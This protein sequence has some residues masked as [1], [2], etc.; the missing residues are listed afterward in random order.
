MERR[1]AQH[2]VDLSSL[3]AILVTHEHSDHC[4]GVAA[5]AKHFNLPVYLSHGTYASDRLGELPQVQL[6]DA[7]SSFAIGDIDVDAVAVPHDAR[8]PVQYRF[9]HDRHTVGVLT[10]L[11]FV[12]PHVL[13]HYSACDVLV[14]EFNHDPRMLAHGP[15]P[16]HLKRRVGG[17]W[18]HLSND[19]AVSLL[20]AADLSRLR[21]LVIAHTSEKNNSRDE[22]L[23]VLQREVPQL[24]ATVVWAQQAEG[25][26]WLNTSPATPDAVSKEQ[27]AE[28]ATAAGAE[29]Y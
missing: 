27:H 24:G 9:R 16:S 6:L 2:Q 28:L 23:G 25:F 26:D 29:A 20:Q 19:Q 11:G 15:Y 7:D 22:I 3:T 14:L 21:F 5:L 8:E 18:G 17:D 10:D 4:S 12:T 13:S 1:A